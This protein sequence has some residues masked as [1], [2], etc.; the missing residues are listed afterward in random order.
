VLLALEREKKH[1]VSAEEKTGYFS[2]AV[3]EALEEEPLASW[4]PNM[5]V[6]A[7]KVKQQVTSLDKKQKP[8]FYSRNW[9]GNIKMNKIFSKVAKAGNRH[10]SH[11]F[12][13]SNGDTLWVSYSRVE[14]QNYHRKNWKNLVCWRKLPQII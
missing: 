11:F 5:E 13:C 10:F 12:S 1:R 14:T 8:T 3:R 4:P 7:K 6:I 2:Q 9:D